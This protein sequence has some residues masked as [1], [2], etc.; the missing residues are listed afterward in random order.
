[1]RKVLFL[2][3]TQNNLHESYNIKYEFTEKLIN[4]KISVVTK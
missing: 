3:F 2:N 1:M 4:L